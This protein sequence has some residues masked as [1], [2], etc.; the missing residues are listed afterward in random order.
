V[1]DVVRIHY[2]LCEDFAG[3]E[4]P[5]GYG[6]VKSQA[7]LE[8]AVGRQHTGFGPFRKYATP[9]AN[10]ATLTFGICCDHP[11]HNGNK[12]TALVS[13]LAHLDKNRLTL[14]GT[15]RQNELYDMMLALADRR[16][17]TE[18]IAPR[19]RRRVGATRRDAEHQVSELAQWL[20]DRVDPVR[21]GE[22]QVTFRQLRTILRGHGYDLEV[23]SGNRADVIRVVP[24]KR[25]LLR[26]ESTEERQRIGRIGYHS[27]G[28]QVSI[29]D[30]KQVRRI[31]HLTEEDGCDSA[32]FYEGADMVDTF[33]NRYRTVLRRLA[34]T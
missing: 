4:D 32:S 15:V 26:R 13:M 27:E 2:V 33:V 10:A 3:E 31:A 7:L 23:S 12:R 21:R 22:R 14:K 9:V 16:F 1:D 19:T 6:G 8:S 34:K 18:R 5:I 20:G 28:E 30:I 25:G 29:K 11:F 24:R 17:S